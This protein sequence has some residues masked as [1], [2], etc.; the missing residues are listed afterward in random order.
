MRGLLL[1]IMLYFGDTTN[2]GELLN[3]DSSVQGDSVTTDLALNVM[4]NLHTYTLKTYSL[5][6]DRLNLQGILNT[7]HNKPHPC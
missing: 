3:K 4:G 6:G 2:R 1:H 7:K 5:F